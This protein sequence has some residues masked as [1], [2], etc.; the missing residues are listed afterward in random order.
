MRRDFLHLGASLRRVLRRACAEAEFRRIVSWLSR[1]DAAL[2]SPRQQVGVKT[3]TVKLTSV[4]NVSLCR[5]CPWLNAEAS[6]DAFWL[7]LI[8]QPIIA[9]SVERQ[10]FIHPEWPAG[11]TLDIRG[12][13][14]GKEAEMTERN[15]RRDVL[16]SKLPGVPY[17]R[18]R[19]RLFAQSCSPPSPSSLQSDQSPA[20]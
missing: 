8:T 14:R 11:M 18:K 15:W 20:G 1:Q 7:K 12:D 4:V 2:D 17:R 5:L 6:D 3:G 19:F 16:N 9:P 10:N 13:V